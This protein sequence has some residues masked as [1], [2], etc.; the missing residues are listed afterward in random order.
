MFWERWFAPQFA[1]RTA[2]LTRVGNR[3]P[4]SAEDFPLLAVDEEERWS[5]G[6]WTR[7]LANA[8]FSDR[9]RLASP[10]KS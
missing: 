5:V 1:G 4:A 2:F 9:A 7:A 3:V 10:S 8:T 6:G